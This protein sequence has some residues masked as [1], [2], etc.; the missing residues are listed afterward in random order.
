MFEVELLPSIIINRLNEILDNADDLLDDWMDAESFDNSDPE[1]V[2][3]L[4]RVRQFI[5]DQRHLILF[6]R[7]Q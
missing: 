5:S 7:F 6:G 2:N 3:N 1:I 4:D